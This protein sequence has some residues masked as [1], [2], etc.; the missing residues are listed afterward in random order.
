MA[1]VERLEKPSSFAF[2]LPGF[3]LRLMKMIMA[4]AAERIN[5]DES[6][7][8]LVMT[9]PVLPR[10]IMTKSVMPTLAANDTVKNSS[11][12]KYLPNLRAFSSKKPGM[13]N[14]SNI[15]AKKNSCDDMN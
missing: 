6:K 11:N 5:M 15:A 13:K 7:L 4:H 14:T 9:I 2:S 8:I 10:I 1:T 3:F 12:E